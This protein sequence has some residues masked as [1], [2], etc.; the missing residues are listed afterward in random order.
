MYLLL[1]AEDGSWGLPQQ[2]WAP[3]ARARQ[4]LQALIAASCGDDLQAHQVGNAPAAHLGDVFVWRFQHV[5]GEV[6]PPAGTHAWLTKQELAER[7]G[8][9]LGALALQVC[10][11][12]P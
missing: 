12:L 1:Q 7:L 8:G 5:Q 6:V 2:P 10:D 4:G 9:P 11:T 3:P